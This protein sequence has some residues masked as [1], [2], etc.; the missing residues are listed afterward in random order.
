MLTWFLKSM[1]LYWS[2]PVFLSPPCPAYCAE[3]CVHGRCMAPNTCQCEP[4]WGGSNC[5]SGKSSSC[6][7]LWVVMFLWVCVTLF[8]W[9]W[10]EHTRGKTGGLSDWSY[11]V[12]HT[13]SE[14]LHRNKILCLF[15]R[16]S[17]FFFAFF[18]LVVAVSEEVKRGSGSISVYLDCV[19][20]SN[21]TSV[22]GQNTEPQVD[23]QLCCHRCVCMNGWFRG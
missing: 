7:C 15:S 16:F 5:S 8:L 9:K 1:W 21:S 4:G 6:R 18:F 11:H 19:S 10:S 12:H 2:L 13:N 20:S 22:F 17:F 14:K 23:W 3:S